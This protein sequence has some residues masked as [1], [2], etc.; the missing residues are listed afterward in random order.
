[1]DGTQKVVVKGAP[2]RVLEMCGSGDFASPYIEQAEALAEEGYRVLALAE[3]SLDSLWI[4]RF[5]FSNKRKEEY[6]DS[7][8]KGR[9]HI[10][11]D[12]HSQLHTHTRAQRLLSMNEG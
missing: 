3:G 10:I 2:E 5:V 1:M 6:S 8:G 9:F 7:V 11:R 12:D 4:S